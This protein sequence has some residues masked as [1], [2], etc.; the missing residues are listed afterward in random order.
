MWYYDT[1]KFDPYDPDGDGIA[2]DQDGDGIPDNFSNPG[3]LD[4]ADE[5]EFH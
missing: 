5:A 1:L 2:D 4:V 3:D